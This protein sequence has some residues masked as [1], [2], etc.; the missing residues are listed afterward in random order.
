MIQDERIIG[1]VHRF[2]SVE[3]NVALDSMEL[4]DA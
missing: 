2:E 4:S 1:G 3:G